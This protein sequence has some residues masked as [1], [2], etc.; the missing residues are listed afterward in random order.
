MRDGR[1]KG[2]G[3]GEMRDGIEK[4]GEGREEEEREGRM[5]WGYVPRT[6][7]QHGS[8]ATDGDV[9]ICGQGGIDNGT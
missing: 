5:T 3:M 6:F 2:G 8:R 9:S 1:G 7:T 4:R